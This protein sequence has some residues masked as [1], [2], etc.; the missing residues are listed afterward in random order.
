MLQRLA[1]LFRRPRPLKVGWLLLGNVNTGSSRIHG[2]NIHNY[3]LEQGVES[4]IL[5][6]SP[7][8]FNGLQLSREQQESVLSAGFNVLMFQKVRDENVQAFVQEARR[9]GIRTV[10]IQCDCIETDM[11]TGVDDVV[12]TSRNLRDFYQGK[13]GIEAQ[14]IEDAIEVD[15]SRAKVHA[16]KEPLGLVWVGHS[17]NWDSVGMVREVLSLPGGTG[18]T[19][20]TISNHPD[21]DV[22]WAID[23]VTD[24]ILSQDIAVIPAH[25]QHW[26]MAKSSNRLTMFM[27]LGM[28]VIASPVPSYL[29]VVQNGRNGFVAGNTPEWLDAL[30]KLRDVETRAAVG[31]QAREDAKRDFSLDTIGPQ[32]LR[33][34]QSWTR[35]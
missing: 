11:V 18:F 10:F 19:L 13:Y 28:P 14:I 17:D 27:A 20:K 23:T 7:R 8:M 4:V 15:P 24:E 34:L 12:V 1:T 9:R 6:S 16:A 33:F 26:G 2:L 22:P 3:L 31:K 5:Q 30:A 29:D 25:L 32:W 35:T 21:A